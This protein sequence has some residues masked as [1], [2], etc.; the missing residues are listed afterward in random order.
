MLIK[1]NSCENQ[2]L[3]FDTFYCSSC[4]VR[5]CFN[6]TNCYFIEKHKFILFS[7][8]TESHDSSN[9]GYNYRRPPSSEMYCEK[10]YI[11]VTRLNAYE[12]YDAYD[13]EFYYLKNK[14]ERVM[15]R[16]TKKHNTLKDLVN[17]HIGSV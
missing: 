12:Q 17:K 5:Y 6:C 11:Y 1:C 8:K 7:D 15:T 13:T 14:I 9:Y 2:A 16:F 4:S 10:C 3:P